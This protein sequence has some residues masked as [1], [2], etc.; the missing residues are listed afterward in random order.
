MKFGDKT[1]ML[2]VYLGED[3]MLQGKPLCWGIKGERLGPK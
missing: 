1:K 2:R 3:D